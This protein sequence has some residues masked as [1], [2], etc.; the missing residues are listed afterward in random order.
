VG[1]T[2]GYLLEWS[3]GVAAALGFCVFGALGVLLAR[4][5]TRV[6][7]P[8]GR[9]ALAWPASRPARWSPSSWS[10]R[11]STSRSCPR[12]RAGCRAR[13][14]PGGRPAPAVDLP[15]QVDGDF[16]SLAATG[17]YSGVVDA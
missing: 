3:L 17:L 6:A 2:W 9:Q 8:R 12:Q 7:V 15:T 11:S 1:I 13:H 4:Y 16:D 14:Q 10:S 5:A